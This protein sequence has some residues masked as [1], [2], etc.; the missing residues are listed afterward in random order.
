MAI[1]RCDDTDAWLGP[2]RAPLIGYVLPLVNG[3]MQAAE[4]VVQE[5]MLRGWQHSTELEPE[6]GRSW[7]HTVARNIAISGYHRRRKSRP[8][9]VPLDEN[10]LPFA[11][12]NA[13]R[14]PDAWLLDVASIAERQRLEAHLPSCPVC[15]EELRRLAPMPGL[16]AGIPERMREPGGAPGQRTAPP[17][18][19]LRNGDTRFRRAAVATACLAAAVTGGFWLFSGAGGRQAAA[20]TF[21]GSNPA[22]HVSATATLTPTSWGTSIQLNVRGLPENVECHLV[23]HSRTGRT[24]VSGVWDDWQH[25][26]VSVPASAS[27]LPSDI[28]GLQVTTAVGNLVTISVVEPPSRGSQGTT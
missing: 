28:A 11:D 18:R 9:E 13:D 15:Q 26:P 8:R 25:G 6:R 2:Q 1:S 3:D 22:T 27:W 17:R 24:E 20:Q 7:L 16:L 4:D 23:V 14:L 19:A 21:A 5:A 12:D 10:A